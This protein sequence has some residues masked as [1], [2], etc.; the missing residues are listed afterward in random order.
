MKP[1]DIL[2]EQEI[3]REWVHHPG[4]RLMAQKLRKE[5]K[6]AK[7]RQLE[8]DPYT[9]PDEIMKCKHFIFVLTVYLPKLIEG[10]VNYEATAIDKMVRP[11][12]RWNVIRWFK[13]SKK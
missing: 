6:R 12:D 3:L 11:S 5:V 4:T 8:F 7:I 13:R 2:R 9:Q 1:D 10:I